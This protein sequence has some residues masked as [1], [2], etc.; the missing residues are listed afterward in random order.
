MNKRQGLRRFCVINIIIASIYILCMYPEPS[1][2]LPED[3]IARL[4]MSSVYAVTFSPDGKMLAVASETGI[5]LYDSITLAQVGHFLGNRVSSIAFSPDG[6][7]LAS[8]S[9]E[10]NTVK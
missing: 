1:L 5:Y 3:A 2:A 9:E 6:S 10:D 8:G 4:G 7:L